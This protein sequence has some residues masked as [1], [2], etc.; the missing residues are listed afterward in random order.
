MNERFLRSYPAPGLGAVGAPLL[1]G[2][3]GL[4]PFTA[5]PPQPPSPIGAT[6]C[7]QQHNQVSCQPPPP[8]PPR[9]SECRIPT[10]HVFSMHRA[11]RPSFPSA[12]PYPQ[13]HTPYPPS[14]THPHPIPPPP[15]CLKSTPPFDRIHAAHPPSASYPCPMPPSAS[16]PHPMPS[17]CLFTRGTL[18]PPHISAQETIKLVFAFSYVWSIGGNVNQ[19]SQEKFDNYAREALESCAF[20][21]PFGMVFDFQVC[22]LLPPLPP[23]LPSSSRS[24]SLGP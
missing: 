19:A 14:A 12:Y 7:R 1:V 23:P 10:T 5:V 8:P 15:L 2:P 24:S 3:H 20:F 16:D 6:S 21:P 18:T 17:L 13:T 9:T 11:P 4:A 22:V